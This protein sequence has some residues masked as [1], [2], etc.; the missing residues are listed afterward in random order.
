MFRATVSRQVCLGINHVSGAYEQIF[1]RQTF[2]G[3]LL[4]GALSHEKLG[5]LYITAGGPRQSSH[6]QVRIPYG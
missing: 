3:L 1:N 4:W 2:A 5:L 6:F